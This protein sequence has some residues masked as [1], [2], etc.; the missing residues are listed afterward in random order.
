MR[1]DVAVDLIGPWTISIG[2]KE[3]KFSALTIIDMVTNLV[4]A[5]RIDN[6][7]SAHIAL[8]FENTWLSR[9]PRP[10]NVI[11]DQGGEFTGDDF[12]YRLEVHDI[13]STP[14]TS[15]NP[16]ANSVCE[17]MHQS[18]GN[19]LRVL[20]TLEKPRGVGSAK[21]LVDTAIADAVYATR[22]T[23]HSTLRTT[24]GGLAFGRDMILNIPLQT[25]LL[26]LQ[27]RRQ[28]LIDQRLIAANA[29][30]IVSVDYR[31]GQEVLKLVYKPD[32]LEP[33][34]V[35]PYRI[36]RVHHNG[37]LSIELSPGVIE[38][39]NVRRVKPYHR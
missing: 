17:R 11:H 28:E 3:L 4:E 35:G 20:Q 8:Q 22:C 5:V 21:Q 26:Q 25:D 12:Q 18:I 6:K 14:I 13:H 9:Y 38:R 19:T 23:F 37:T 31:E 27:K 30:R 34:A 2:D 39:I 1:Q 32:K 16:Q 24:P 29:K 7:T 15:K 10:M 36:K 33:R